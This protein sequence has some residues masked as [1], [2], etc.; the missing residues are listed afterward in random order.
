MV[1]SKRAWHA[2]RTPR[3][4]VGRQAHPDFCFLIRGLTPAISFR[5]VIMSN[6]GGIRLKPDP[7]TVKSDLHRLA[8]FKQKIAAV[9]VQLD[10][11]IN[12]YAATGDD[13]FRKPRTEMWTEMRRDYDLQAPNAIDLSASFYVGDAGGRSG[14]K[15]TRNDH[16]CSDRLVKGVRFGE[17]PVG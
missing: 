14:N 2:S 8:V 1:G 7:K 3:E 12:L 11:P 5:V 9:L 10:L 15:G 6:Q 17:E 4:G 16:A 13:N